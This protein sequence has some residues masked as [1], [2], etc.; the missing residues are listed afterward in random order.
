[1]R[2][3]FLTIIS[4][5]IIISSE[6]QEIFHHISNRSVYDFLDEMANI[7]LIEINSAYRPYS[8]EFI[9]EKLHEIDTQREQLNKRQAKDLDFF[10]KDF[11]KELK[12]DKHFKKRFDIFYYKDSLFTFSINPI[13]GFHYFTNE[14]GSATHWWNGLE[15][16]SSFGKH[17]G[18][19]ASLRDNHDAE[20][21]S[22]PEYINQRPGANYKG[23][24]DYSEMRGGI[25]WSWEWGSFGLIKDHFIWGNNYNGA[26]I[27]S[28]RTPSFGQIY[29]SLK[30]VKWFEFKYVH[31]WLISEVV[32]ST[33]SYYYT[34]GRG[35]HYREVYHPKYIAANLFTFTPFKK[36]N[37]SFGNSIVY[38]DLGTFPTY[39]IPFAF[40]KSIDHTVNHGNDNQNS[41][42]FFDFS[43][44]QIKNLHL[45]TTLF[46]DELSTSRMFDKDQH[47]N[48]YSWKI[49]GRLSN[50][51]LRNIAIT[52]EYTRTNPLTYKHP[53]PTL[54]F[55]S[56]KYNL[57][58]YATDNNQEIFLAVEAKPI[59][60]LWIQ[61]SFLYIQKG[62]DYSYLEGRDRWGLPFME[63]V[64]WENSTFRLDARY[65][66]INDAFI[67][68][69]YRYSNI[70]G[71]DSDKYTHP[72]WQGK[73]NTFS[74]GLTFGF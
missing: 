48:F 52:A 72:L 25:T 11:N 68:A 24:G 27:F 26:N 73:T 46:F 47:S 32:D 58:Y 22:N 8:R 18:I 35:T 12:P 49:G 61:T 10:L 53:V 56:N 44:R 2:K 19:Y 60:G 34:N 74:A 38:A 43:S 71:N 16:F 51:P 6:A 37:A 45:Y 14:N 54:K 65:E 33:R 59:R 69:G 62:P 42:M 39:L 5:L 41:Q 23:N 70:S 4:L 40:F 55:T 20:F 28:G 57:G 3:I 36:F 7:Q 66:I 67:S 31:G 13:L 9:A 17:L 15:M 30:P 29:L 63:S 21:L 64:E 1:M 50:F